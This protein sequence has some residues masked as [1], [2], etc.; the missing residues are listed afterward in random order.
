[1]SPFLFTNTAF[2]IAFA[3]LAI[4]I[5][6]HLLL[7][8]KKQRLR[9]STI[10]FFA[11]Q[12]ERSAHRRKLR[13]LI[14]LATRLLLLALLVLAFARPYLPTAAS[15]DQPAPQRQLVLV[16]D[17]SASMQAGDRW[18]QAMTAARGALTG[19][20]G[21][22]RVALIDATVPARVLSQPVPPAK[23]RSLLDDLTPGFGVSD[24]G[25]ALREAVKFLPVDGSTRAT[26]HVISDLQRSACET[27][28]SAPVPQGVETR[29]AL[30]GEPYLPNLTVSGLDLESASAAR[31][32]LRSYSDE[33]ARGIPVEVNVNGVAA[34]TQFVDLPARAT[35]ELLLP[36]PA[37]DPGWHTL[38]AR[39]SSGDRFGLDDVR[40][41]VVRVPEPVPTVCVELSSGTVPYEAETY[42]LISALNP[43]VGSVNG[44]QLSPFQPEQIEPSV[45]TR[46]LAQ[47]PSPRLIFLPAQR[48]FPPE[49]GPE[50]VRFVEQGGGLALFVGESFSP[51]R[52]LAEL[53]A[54]LP[55]TPGTAEG[56]PN[57]PETHWRMSAIDPHTPLF[58]AFRRPDSGD[59]S[60]PVFKRRFA[61]DPASHAQ[62]PAR[63]IDGAPFVV[64]AEF[65]QGRVAFIN[66]T[67]DTT[68]T[69]WP[70]RR[71]FVPWIHGLA[72]WLLA[73]EADVA[74]SAESSRIA[75]AEVEIALGA[76]AFQETLFIGA[77]DGTQARVNAD[78]NGRFR[79]SFD[80]PGV[81]SVR[82]DN[83]EELRRVAVNLPRTA[84]DLNALTPGEFQQRLVRINPSAESGWVSGLLDPVRDE[85]HFGR[86][87]LMAGAF[88]LLIELLL[89][90]RTFA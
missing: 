77:P 45:L 14:L 3:A 22:D 65:G 84:S 85:R 9:F 74:A 15:A 55:A 33:P 87:L 16:L 4:P 5:L 43:Q 83:G 52:Y 17:R 69:D 57:R 46:R 24:L 73:G 89:A 58:H 21:N 51:I 40:H 23:V 49:L 64:T 86:L 1:M 30:I 47:A 44:A 81:Y 39:I 60:L 90:N 13:N 59:L 10:R 28:A 66:T 70:K 54:L 63:F 8:R 27:V 20:D 26:L 62:V 50:L 2:L 78:E 76:G 25:D 11:R 37:L 34:A 42:F 82:R 35:T 36:L 32:E 41:Q 71:T 19:L 38:T 12:D 48:L 79:V 67:P 18:A 68:W 7:R 72:H 61:L 31:V 88:L 75:G 29:V 6:I 53:S 80:R 56:E